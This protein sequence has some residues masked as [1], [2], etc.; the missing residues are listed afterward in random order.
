[1]PDLAQEVKDFVREKG[2]RLVGI[3]SM[4]RFEGAPKGHH[5][6]NLLPE[7]NSV[8]SIA[9]RFF[10]T[11]LE[12]DQFGTESELIPKDELW[13]VQQTVF[14]FMYDTDNVQLQTMGIQLATFLSDQGY[15]TLPLP[16][17][18][19]RVGAGRYA[20]FSH[21]HAAVLAGLGGF[22]LNNLLV[23]PQ[24]GPRVRLCS[25]ITAA[26]LTPDPMLADTPCPGEACGVCLEAHTCFGEI[27]E[28]ELGGRKARMARFHGCQTDLC[29][30]SNRE[31]PLPYIRYCWGVCPI[32]KERG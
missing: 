15:R 11:T 1:M 19:F 17:G 14:R 7:A 25:I 23:T 6:K 27:H 18:G 5:P 32:G 31:G 22:G 3:A 10:Q 28:F 8:I 9:V 29:K 2:A 21:R 12:C 24:Y 30:R 4:D 26:K 16:A 20:F 13:D